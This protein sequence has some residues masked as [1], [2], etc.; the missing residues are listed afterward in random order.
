MNWFNIH[1]IFKTITFG[2]AFSCVSS[3]TTHQIHPI[4]PNIIFIL[5]DD[6]SYVDFSV[7]GQKMFETPYIDRLAREGIMFTE[8]YSGSPECAP[9][10]ASLMTGMHMGHCRIR[11]NR[12]VRGQDHLLAEDITI[13]EVLKEAGYKTGFVGK[14]GI[15]LPET[16]GTPNNQGFDYSYGFYDQLR[17]HGFYPDY[18]MENDNRIIIPENHG[19]NMERVYKYNRRP[20]GN[21]DNVKNEYD[22]QGRFI[23]DGVS[24]PES[25]KN[26][27]DLIQQAALDFIKR[28][29]NQSFFLYYATQLPHGPLITPNLGEFQSNQWD[30]KHKEWAAMMKHLDDHIGEL[31]AL[32]EE[33]QILENTFIF[34]AGDNGYSQWGYFGRKAWEDDPL[35]QNKGPWDKGK[36]ICAD[37]GVRI[38]FFVYAKKY[39]KPGKSKHLCTLYD[40]FETAADL[41]GLAGTYQTDGISFLPVLL[42][43]SSEQQKHDYL[44][45]E[46]G[47]FNPHAQ[48][49]RLDKWFAFR[50]HPDKPIELYDSHHD[51]S[52]LENV[53]KQNPEIIA[54]IQTIYMDAHE[55]SRWYSNP[56]ESEEE[57]QRKRKKAESENSLQIPVKA[58]TTY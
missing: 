37:G 26:S 56:G 38:P 12:S 13:A 50:S 8:A 53:A 51:K 20:V 25:V 21:I 1:N 3:C 30:L 49:V 52:C 9:A 28:N 19:F 2:I 23:A 43:S 27:Q 42:N 36:F 48:A 40:F 39:I 16:E 6:V 33:Q 7:M 15:G 54:K 35:F 29:A 41:A 24:D 47:T 4:K 5:S 57:I 31:Y 10:R 34:F 58:N 55:D 11:A 46:N 22:K 18:L 45:W 17:A 14:W 32:L 44:Y